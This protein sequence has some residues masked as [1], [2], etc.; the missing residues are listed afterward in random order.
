MAVA[1]FAM[2]GFTSCGGHPEE[3]AAVAEAW[4]D[5]MA[6]EDIETMVAL[7]TFNEN[8]SEDLREAAAKASVASKEFSLLKNKEDK[9]YKEIDDAE[10][11]EADVKIDSDNGTATVPF[12]VKYAD[13][14]QTKYKVTL[15]KIA[16]KWYVN[17]AYEAN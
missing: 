2:V 12:T 10:L 6:G 17:Y 7:E 15:K 11:I 5:A 9:E 1:L 8:Y 4:M 16:D 3:P 14:S 13:G